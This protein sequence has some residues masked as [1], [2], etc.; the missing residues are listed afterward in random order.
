MNR[1]ILL[2]KRFACLHYSFRSS[3]VKA[4]KLAVES[5]CVQQRWT[6]RQMKLS[7]MPGYSLATTVQRKADHALHIATVMYFYSKKDAKIC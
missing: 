7:Q 5:I 2:D 1:A 4:E 6:R 3:G